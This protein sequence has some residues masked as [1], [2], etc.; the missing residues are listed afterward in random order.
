MSSQ[1]SDSCGA[2]SQRPTN[3]APSTSA[4]TAYCTRSIYYVACGRLWPMTA[5][6][7]ATVGAAVNA[8][9]PLPSFWPCY[10]YAVCVLGR[11]WS[12]HWTGGWL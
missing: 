11:I 12:G 5:S 3:G 7:T 6:T 8:D 10:A 4:K 2:R 1:T 9:P